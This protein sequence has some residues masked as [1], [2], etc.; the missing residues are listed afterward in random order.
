MNRPLPGIL[1]EV[2]ILDWL[3]DYHEHLLLVTFVAKREHWSLLGKNL[4]LGGDLLYIFL[5]RLSLKHVSHY[6]D[7]H[8]QHGDLCK[9]SCSDEHQYD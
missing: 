4:E 1:F 2:F 7:Q 8:V 5:L 6:S 3:Y 9:E